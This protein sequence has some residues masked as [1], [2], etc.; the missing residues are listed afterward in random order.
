MRRSPG[1]HVQHTSRETC[2]TLNLLGHIQIAVSEA[3]SALATI[4]ALLVLPQ[5]KCQNSPSVD[6]IITG[7]KMFIPVLLILAQEAKNK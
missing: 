1:M 6:T 7:M 2:I 3:L 4:A 5:L